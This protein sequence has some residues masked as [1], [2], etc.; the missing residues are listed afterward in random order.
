MKLSPTAVWE[1]RLVGYLCGAASSCWG[2]HHTEAA[3]CEFQGCWRG[4]V[5]RSNV[6][7]GASY[8]KNV[9]CKVTKM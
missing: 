3:N 6:V 1:Q 7:T 4:I 8:N 5:S 9:R 2:V